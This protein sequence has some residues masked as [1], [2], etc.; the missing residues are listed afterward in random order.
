MQ[1]TFNVPV[2]INRHILSQLTVKDLFSSRL[3]SYQWHGVASQLL[4]QKLSTQLS[5]LHSQLTDL[6][7]E[8]SNVKS[9]NEVAQQT[10]LVHLRVNTMHLQ[11]LEEMK[12]YAR[13]TEEVHR[14]CQY[15]L[16]LKGDITLAQ[17]G[18]HTNL[19]PWCDVR[20]FV[21]RPSF[22]Q[23][24]QHLGA[25]SRIMPYERVQLVH[26]MFQQPLVRDSLQYGSL[27]RKSKPGYLMLVL[28]AGLVRQADLKNDVDEK[29]QEV[30]SVSKS[31]VLTTKQLQVVTESF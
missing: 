25:F 7:S 15:L 3:V 29:Q 26:Y 18:A 12:R 9:V 16:V 14:V 31:I 17:N 27:L 19:L 11:A 4:N 13:P 23:W 5:S 20:K 21:C 28:L 30:A 6:T 1:H 22:K 8:L 2:E 24:L 10:N